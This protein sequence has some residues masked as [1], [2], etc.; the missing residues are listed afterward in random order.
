MVTLVKAD[1]LKAFRQPLH[2]NHSHLGFDGDMTM[3][4][5]RL[6]YLSKIAAIV[7][8]SAFALAGCSDATPDKSA[9][10]AKVSVTTSFY[11]LTYL[12][13]EVGQDHV[14]VTDLTPPGA[15]AHG[16]ELSPKEISDMQKSDVVFYLAKLSPAI[17]DAVAAAKV[18]AINIGD[19]VELLKNKETGGE[20][21]HADHD[22]HDEHA[23][24]DHDGEHA[25]HD[26]HDEHA[27]HDHG[28]YDPH[29]WT[30]PARMAQAAHTIAKQLS[31]KDPKHTTDYEKNADKVA[32]R[33]LDLDKKFEQAFAGNCETKSFV[34]THAAFGYLAHEYG[35]KQIGVA[36]IDP[37]FEPSPARIAEVKKLVDEE[38]INTIFTPTNGEAKVAQTVAQETGAQFAVLNVAATAGDESADYIDMMEHNLTAL[39]D[40]MR[41]AK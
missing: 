35:L 15:D 11:P 6:S 4:N 8:A 22:E 39:S 1:T 29:F 16:V 19:S 25:D 37:E 17:D 18:N 12:V 20:H 14:A 9:S 33:L 23:H 13:N 26:E 38:H 21:E 7:S 3:K 34:V 10:D 24:H 36:G 5:K 40:S 27:H 41:C 2:D 28:I 32:K 31:E 30:D